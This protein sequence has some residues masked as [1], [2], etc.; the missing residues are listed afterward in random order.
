VCFRTLRALDRGRVCDVRSCPRWRCAGGTAPL[1]PT[2]ALLIG[3]KAK[4]PKQAM[5]CFEKQIPLSPPPSLTKPR[6]TNPAHLNLFSWG[7]CLS[8]DRRRCHV[9]CSHGDQTRR[10]SRMPCPPQ[11][12]GLFCLLFVAVWT[13]SKASAGRDP[14]SCLVFDLGNNPNQNR[15]TKFAGPGRQPGE[16]LCSPKESNQRKGVR[17]A[18][19]LWHSRGNVLISNC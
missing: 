7:R 5:A 16:F 17:P 19:A 14:R 10:L 13:K 8:V 18:N 3:R 9:S 15:K 1:L 6:R 2:P 12:K 11:E 4:K